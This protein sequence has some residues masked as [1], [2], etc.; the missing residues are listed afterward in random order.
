MTID[1]VSF[2]I[3]IVVPMLLAVAL[4]GA[5]Y[6]LDFTLL[7]RKAKWVILLFLAM[8]ILAVPFV[9]KSGGESVFFFLITLMH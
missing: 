4:F 9:E 3:D 7:A 6:F 2:G 8:L 5:A 1:Q